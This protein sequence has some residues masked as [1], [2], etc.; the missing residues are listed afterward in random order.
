MIAAGETGP[1]S[2]A[3]PSTR[4]GRLVFVGDDYRTRTKTH[5]AGAVVFIVRLLM[6]IANMASIQTRNV[7]SV[8][9]DSRSQPSRAH[10]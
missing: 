1:V 2:A 8:N 3:A 9:S 7:G 4:R 6:V 10:A 5:P